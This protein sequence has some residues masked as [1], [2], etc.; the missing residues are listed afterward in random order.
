MK[1]KAR[2]RTPGH[3]SFTPHSRE[4]SGK[5]SAGGLTTEAQLGRPDVWKR[6]VKNGRESETRESGQVRQRG[7]APRRALRLTKLDSGIHAG[8]SW[9]VG[10]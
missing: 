8:Q 2:I 6:A 5:K 10:R 7:G 4:V 3:S 1:P 9:R